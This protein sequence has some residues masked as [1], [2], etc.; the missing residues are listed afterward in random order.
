MDRPALEGVVEV[1]AMGGGAVAEGRPGCAHRTPVT[2]RSA[3][4]VLV[5]ARKRAADVVLVARSDAKTDHVDRGLLAFLARRRGQLAG[6]DRR[7]PLGQMLGQRNV[8]ELC[9]H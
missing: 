4:A 9:V 8:G 6:V 7:D 5:P 3:W 1:L 2:D